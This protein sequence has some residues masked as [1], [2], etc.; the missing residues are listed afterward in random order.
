[1]R[2]MTDPPSTGAIVEHPLSPV[3]FRYCHGRHDRSISRGTVAF[4]VQF[5]DIGDLRIPIQIGIDVHQRP[6]G[7]GIRHNWGDLA[8]DAVIRSGN[9]LRG[10]QRD[11]YI[12]RANQAF[13][14]FIKCG[15]RVCG[16]CG[17]R[18]RDVLPCGRFRTGLDIIVIIVGGIALF[19]AV[20]L[21]RHSRWTGGLSA[22]PG[23]YQI[24]V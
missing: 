7:Y 16:Q 23:H 15:L 17:R 18:M 9:N 24:I 14:R 8:Q 1:M 20:S 12:L 13:N 19:D 2:N 11:G 3:F 21:S 4:D 10:H 5:V 22:T 6:S